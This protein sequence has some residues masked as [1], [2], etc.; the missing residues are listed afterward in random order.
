MFNSKITYKIMSEK[1]GEPLGTTLV[2]KH[3]FK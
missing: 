2:S 3:L 1:N